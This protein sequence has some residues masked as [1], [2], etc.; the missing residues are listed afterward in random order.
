MEILSLAET[1]R[2]WVR[3][4]YASKGQGKLFTSIVMINVKQ[5]CILDVKL[6][7]KGDLENKT[8]TVRSELKQLKGLMAKNKTSIKGESSAGS[9]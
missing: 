5:L 1:L 3:E 6:L 7:F 2:T 9:G 8:Q 4:N